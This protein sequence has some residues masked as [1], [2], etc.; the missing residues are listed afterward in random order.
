MQLLHE[1]STTKVKEFIKS[2]YVKTL[3]YKEN[4]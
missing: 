2:E 3:E 4:Y 1:F